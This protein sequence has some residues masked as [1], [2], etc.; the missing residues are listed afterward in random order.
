MNNQAETID[1]RVKLIELQ[2]HTIQEEIQEIIAQ[3]LTEIDEE[4]GTQ[5]KGP[6]RDEL[7]QHTLNCKSIEVLQ[8]VLTTYISICREQ[9]D[10]FIERFKYLK[11]KHEATVKYLQETEL[12]LETAQSEIDSSQSKEEKAQDTL[13]NRKELKSLTERLGTEEKISDELREQVS[14]L[15]GERSNLRQELKINSV[16][17]KEIRQETSESNK[18]AK[19]EDIAFSVKN[20]LEEQLQC[21]LKVN[22]IR[23]NAKKRNKVS[24]TKDWSKRYTQ[25]LR[26]IEKE[27]EK[28]QEKLDK[29]CPGNNLSLNTFQQTLDKARSVVKTPGSNQELAPL[30]SDDSDVESTSQLQQSNTLPT[31]NNHLR[32]ITTPE[33]KMA[34]VKIIE[35]AGLVNSMVPILNGRKGPDLASEVS[36]FITCARA[37][38]K[39][40][41]TKEDEAFMLSYL[42]TRCRGDAHRLVDRIIF[43]TFEEFETLLTETYFPYESFAEAESKLYKA[44]QE[45]GES[46]AE[47][48][49]RI[50]RLHTECKGGITNKYGDAPVE[51][52]LNELEEKTK[53]VF[54]RGLRNPIAQL[55]LRGSKYDNL[56]ALITSAIDFELQDVEYETTWPK[57]V[58][59]STKPND[60]KPKLLCAFCNRSGHI[61]KDCYHY[62]STLGQPDPFSR[63]VVTNSTIRCNVCNGIGHYARDCTNRLNPPLSNNVN[64]A[65]Q[66][67]PTNW[68]A[69]S[70]QNPPQSNSWNAAAPPTQYQAQTPK[71]VSQPRTTREVVCYKCN[72]PGHYSHNCPGN[73]INMI[74]SQDMFCRFCQLDGH[75]MDTCVEVA[76]ILMK[77]MQQEN[78]GNEEGQTQG[79]IASAYKNNVE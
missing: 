64:A 27:F 63:P 69:G 73:K 79:S 44:R 40:L 5:E 45:V 59:L 36:A 16:R 25:E 32:I 8:F 43:K 55:S 1:L 77:E 65:T 4:I 38:N 33:I 66:A 37:I 23:D 31:V 61:M 7:Q 3:V 11:R 48:G 13:T 54:L 42:K 28:L 21:I 70:R 19:L 10:E 35:I 18:A 72:Q 34:E 29:I 20:L 2:L 56:S 76:R 58:N 52:L 62:K 41:K 15:Q 78:T 6:F 17:L 50:K 24:R 75:N 68:Q 57:A 47:Y 39:Q 53:K 71:N 67:I 60:E 46:T 30:D 14:S 51:S 22:S 12:E 74:Q 49:I 26:L 9:K